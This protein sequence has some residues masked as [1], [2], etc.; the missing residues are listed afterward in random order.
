MRPLFFRI[1]LFCIYFFIP[2]FVFADIR[3]VSIFP[4]TVDDTNL[5]Y[6][7]IRN[8]GCIDIDISGYAFLDEN[9][10]SGNGN[11]YIFP[12]GT[13]I[14][15]HEILKIFPYSLAKIQLNNTNETIYLKDNQ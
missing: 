15:S 11:P 10:Q 13:S 2:F 8:T 7:E 3:I 4:N 6:I 14:K 12:N 1:L 9:A 5:E